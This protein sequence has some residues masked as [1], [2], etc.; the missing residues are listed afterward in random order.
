MAVSSGKT[1]F[2]LLIVNYEPDIELLMP[3]LM[4]FGV[5]STVDLLRTESACRGTV[6]HR[7]LIWL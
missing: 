7:S 1:P 4:L 2:R 5:R 6:A 3:A